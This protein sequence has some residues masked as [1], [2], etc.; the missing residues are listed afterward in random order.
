VDL[1]FIQR[2]LGSGT[3]GDVE[4][5]VSSE[6]DSLNRL[7]ETARAGAAW[8]SAAS[9]LQMALGLG[10]QILLARW[11]V[12]RE[13]GL[14]ALA[15]SS[16]FVL[17][18]LAGAG[19]RTTVAQQNRKD[20]AD[21]A[22]SAL[23]LALAASISAAILLTA[24]APLL[25]SAFGEPSLTQLIFV[26]AV[27]LPIKAYAD[28]AIPVLRVRFRFGTLA[29]AS[30]IAAVA[31]YG[32]SLSLAFSGFG[33]MA[34]A[35]GGL[36]G[37]TTLSSVLLLSGSLGNWRRTPNSPS[38]KQ[39]AALAAWPFAGEFAIHTT[40]RIDYLVLGLF[41]PTAVVGSYYFA[42]QL[43]ARTAAL[44]TAVSDAVL[45]PIL[46]QIKGEPDRQIRGLFRAVSGFVGVAA[47][48]SAL[49]VAAIPSFEQLVW[50][51]KWIHAVFAIG[52]LASV[53]PIQVA[54]TAP[55]QLLKARGQFRIWTGLLLLRSATVAAAI[56]VTSA[57]WNPEAS[58]AGITGV[59]VAAI[60]VG[61]AIEVAVLSRTL[62]FRVQRF[63]QVT[64][65]ICT[66]LVAIGWFG[67]WLAEVIDLGPTRSLLLASSVVLAAC[68][69]LLA[70]AQRLGIG[71][72]ER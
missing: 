24:I 67:R 17:T 20:L 70:A 14:F 15:I 52:I 42:F 22:P 25:A 23:R 8:I 30:T 4:S 37:V 71:T 55:E 62:G 31:Q 54:V 47:L 2:L 46:S 64:L 35:V 72:T 63:W 39:T 57:I 53:V 13:F 5:A 6:A 45:F 56:T 12:P 59:I 41:A 61:V 33:A 9:A 65:S 27:G 10:S 49:V 44:L 66:P 36:V 34:L 68:L 50:Q 29:V 38:I 19:I 7:G 1:H 48:G 21:I 11:L 3:A 40:I 32:A 51:G 28:V 18:A 58:V 43:V 60:V 26:L 16:A 69:A